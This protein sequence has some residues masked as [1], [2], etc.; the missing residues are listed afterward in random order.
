VNDRSAEIRE[1]LERLEE[2][3]RELEYEALARRAADPEGEDAA[4]AR[5]AER[6]YARARRALVRA[7]AAL[8]GG[9]DDE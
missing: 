9:G 1:R 2:E 3:L 5:E 7:I 4:A 8:G 6:R